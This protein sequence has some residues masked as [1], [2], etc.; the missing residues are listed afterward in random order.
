MPHRRR[1]SPPTPPKPISATPSR[2][3]GD[4]R[5]MRAVLEAG[6]V[7]HIKFL[8]RAACAA[9]A[10]LIERLVFA[11]R[12]NCYALHRRS[13]VS[14]NSLSFKFELIDYFICCEWY[15]VK[16]ISPRI[17]HCTIQTSRC[18]LIQIWI[19]TKTP[20]ASFPN[21][22]LRWIAK[23][24]RVTLHRL[25]ICSSPSNNDPDRLPS[26][27][28]GLLGSG[29]VKRI[30]A[31]GQCQREHS[32]YSFDRSEAQLPPVGYIGE[33]ISHAGN[34]LCVDAEL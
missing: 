8:R 30:P 14:L 24:L 9:K 25:N 20:P 17:L 4:E 18:L 21:F 15:D 26:V 22:H 34:F 2:G 3:G 19:K 13:Q 29:Y 6:K 7:R 5:S 23:G 31:R 33:K 11:P 10:E 12:N 27:C 16:A 1:R 28:K 32:N